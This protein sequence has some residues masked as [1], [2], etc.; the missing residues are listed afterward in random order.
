M[1]VRV[2]HPSRQCPD[3]CV[4]VSPA[5]LRRHNKLHGLAE[6]LCIC[7]GIERTVLDSSALAR[8]LQRSVM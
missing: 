1:N 2:S 3:P 8:R 7:L 5:L 6:R 4:R